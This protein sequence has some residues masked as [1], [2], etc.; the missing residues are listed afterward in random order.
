VTDI[1]RRSALIATAGLIAAPALAAP[2]KPSA[3]DFS[4]TSL[5]DDK[6]DFAQFKGRVVL[7]VNTASFCGY[8]YQYEGLEKLHAA[9]TPAG[10]TVVGMPSTDF[11]Q[12]SASNTAVKE[13]CDATFGVTFPMTEITHVRGAQANAFYKWVKAEKDW[14]PSWNFNKVL[15]GRD[16]QIVQLFGSDAEPQGSAMTGWLDRALKAQAPTA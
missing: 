6:M 4:F 1:T 16:G 5:E 15:I 8:T 14:E 12:E 2:R 11:N 10:L 3:F 13:F 9:L 7:V